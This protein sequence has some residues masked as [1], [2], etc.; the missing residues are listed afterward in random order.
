MR[1]MT[2]RKFAQLLPVGAAA[3]AAV[4]HIMFS[5]CRSGIRGYQERIAAADQLDY[6]GTALEVV[7]AVKKSG[8]PL[9]KNG[10]LFNE[11]VVNHK[12]MNGD[13]GYTLKI[14][15]KGK[16]F[17]VTVLVGKGWNDGTFGFYDQGHNYRGFG[18]LI[19]RLYEE[20]FDWFA[21]V[22]H[23]PFVG[24]SDERVT[25][26]R[27]DCKGKLGVADQHLNMA[28]IRP[29]RYVKVNPDMEVSGKNN[30]TSIIGEP[31]VKTSDQ[32]YEKR[33]P[34]DI[35]GA[36]VTNYHDMREKEQMLYISLM[37]DL[38]SYM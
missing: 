34:S 1:K 26:N 6:E 3:T 31:T 12:E 14:H 15:D 37:N 25:A 36:V 24:Q 21:D 23:V 38:L 30:S 16:H 28:N 18:V 20:D 10:K 29:G 35:R 4:P 27:R 7:E 32:P 8:I 11:A 9:Y 17:N 33:R 5:G 13:I 22:G 19:D 2:R